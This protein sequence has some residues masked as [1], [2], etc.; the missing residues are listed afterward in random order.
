MLFLF[1]NL[2]LISQACGV[3]NNECMSMDFAPRNQNIISGSPKQS[4]EGAVEP[5]LLNRTL[6]KI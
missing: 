5:S 1:S 2:S 6:S 4:A 3:Q